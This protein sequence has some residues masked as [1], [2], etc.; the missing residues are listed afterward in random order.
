MAAK[1]AGGGGG[2]YSLNQNSEIN[3]TPFV[4]ILLVLLIIFMVAV[5]MAVTSIKIDLPPAVPPPPNAPKPKEPVFISIQKSG[6]LFIA[7]KQTSLDN[8]PIDLDAS[9]T[10]KGQAGPKDDQRVMI[11]ADADVLYSDFMGVLNQLQ[12]AG[13]YKVGLINEDIH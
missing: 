1:L 5:P 13:W 10:S 7:D 3:V 9:F 8:L 12:T 6:A 11:R 4:D 2:R